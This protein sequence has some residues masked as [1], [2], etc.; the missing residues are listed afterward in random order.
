MTR[1][2]TLLP[3]TFL[4]LLMMGAHAALAQSNET[5]QDGGDAWTKDCPPD[6]YC[7]YGAGSSCDA[8]NGTDECPTYKGDCGA[9]VCAYGGEGC[10]ECS[11]PV[12]GGSNCMDGQQEGETCRDDVY[13]MAPPGDEPTRGPAD[14]SC[15]NCRGEEADPVSAPASDDAQAKNAVPG[16]ALVGTLAAVGLAGLALRRRG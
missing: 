3:L 5:P 14:G 9:E 8:A 15:E 16:A 2:L 1:T 6:Q 4:A 12:D 10:A 11:G 7:T 13:Y